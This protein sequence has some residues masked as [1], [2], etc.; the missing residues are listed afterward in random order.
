MKVVVTKLI[1]RWDIDALN[2]LPDYM[3]LLYKSFWNIYK[4]IEQEMIKQGR[5]YILNYYEKE[6]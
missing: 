3:K 6:V 2:N 5:L 1:F 4:E